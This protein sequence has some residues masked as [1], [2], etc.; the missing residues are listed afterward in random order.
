MVS[1]TACWGSYLLDS[2]RDWCDDAAAERRRPGPLRHGSG[3]GYEQTAEV[4]AAP[5]AATQV[6]G[7][8]REALGRLSAVRTDNID[9]D[10]QDFYRLLTHHVPRISPQEL[11][12]GLP[13]GHG[14]PPSAS[15]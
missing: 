7:N 8:T 3:D 14:I 15:R 6:S 13:S 10:V 12:E 5:A 1:V 4:L 9:I 11:I 2:Q